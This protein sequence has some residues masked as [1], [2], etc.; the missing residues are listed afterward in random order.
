MLC[1]LSLYKAIK[2]KYPDS[3]ITLVASKTNYDIPYFDINP[4]IDRVLIYDKSS[5]K[6]VFDFYK[7]LRDRKY[8]FGFVPSTIKISRTSHIINFLSGAKI[9][10]GVNSLDGIKN[11]SA[12]LLNLKS[13]FNWEN[14]HQLF[15]NLEIAQLAGFNL[16]KEEIE[17][18]KLP[19]GEE[20]IS[21]AKNF[22]LENFPD[23]SKKIIAFHPGAGKVANT[24]PSEKFLDLIR[25]IYKRCNNYILLTSG[26]TDDRIIGIITA[27]LDKDSI[28]YKVLHNLPVKKLAAILSLVDLY[29]TNDTGT[30]HIAGL[31]GTKMI[32]LF[33]PTNPDEWAPLSKNSYWVKSTTGKIEDISVDDIF[34]LFSKLL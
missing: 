16:T 23:A 26:W 22:L 1:S 4:F 13:D 30:M 2:K 29:I 5:S 27:G 34:N 15:R 31:S 24:Y 3:H 8:D 25:K 20:D 28:S 12:S 14:K 17:E 18:I 21:F 19:L 10:V 32:S 7:R 9:R 6:S 11:K 33:G